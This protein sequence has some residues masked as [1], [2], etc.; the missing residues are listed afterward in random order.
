VVIEPNEWMIIRSLT[1][2][3]KPLPEGYE[4]TW[5][6]LPLFVDTWQAPVTEDPAAEYATTLA[7]GLSNAEH[8]VTLTPN[9]DG[10]IPVAAF[11]VYRPPLR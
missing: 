5:E 6:T 9:G 1:Y 8:T 10:P 3:D 2:R 7:Q 4:V 11:R